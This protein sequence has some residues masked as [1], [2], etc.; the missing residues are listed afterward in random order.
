MASRA[1]SQKK[2]V[3]HSGPSWTDNDLR[4]FVARRFPKKYGPALPTV[5]QILASGNDW[6][7][8]EA[9]LRLL[10]APVFVGKVG[11]LG[12]EGAR[13][14]DAQLV[15][16]QRLHDEH[17]H[18]CQV[19]FEKGLLARLLDDDDEEIQQYAAYLADSSH[20]NDSFS[21]VGDGFAGGNEMDNDIAYHI[22]MVQQDDKDYRHAQIE[23]RTQWEAEE[24]EDRSHAYWDSVIEQGCDS[25]SDDDDNEY[26]TYLRWRRRNGD[27]LPE[28]TY[29][30]DSSGSYTSDGERS[31]PCYASGFNIPPSK[32]RRLDTRALRRGLGNLMNLRESFDFSYGAYMQA[33]DQGCGPGEVGDI[34]LQDQMELE[35]TEIAE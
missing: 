19:D 32:K 7:V 17:R 15:D 35:E 33:L 10:S 30:S 11:Q 9:L 24:N 4:L 20:D 14:T 26:E 22:A 28:D 31:F 23:E 34:P 18:Q 25:P 16:A 27:P 6:N 3:P 8:N 13:W 21:L 5:T 1:R 2:V 29:D 12:T